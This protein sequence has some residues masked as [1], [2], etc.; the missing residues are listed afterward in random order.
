MCRTLTTPSHPQSMRAMLSCVAMA[1]HVPLLYQ[2]LPGPAAAMRQDTAVPC[3]CI[4]LMPSN[5]LGHETHA[6]RHKAP[7]R[8][9]DTD[10]D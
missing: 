5:L 3:K 6:C 1:C 9:P 7:I 10:T 4:T 8:Q 2:L